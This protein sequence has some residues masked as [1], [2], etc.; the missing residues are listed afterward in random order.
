[1]QLEV[2][3]ISLDGCKLLWRVKNIQMPEQEFQLYIF[4]HQHKLHS[5]RLYAAEALPFFV[6]ISEQFRYRKPFCM[7]DSPL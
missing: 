1:M 4:R 5:L 2:Q 3:Y 7:Y 6:F